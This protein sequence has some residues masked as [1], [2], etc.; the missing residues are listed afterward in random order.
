MSNIPKLRFPEFTDAWEKC[1]LERYLKTS[2][3]KNTESQYSKEDVLSVSGEFGI[4]NQIK[5]KGRSFAGA[6]VENYSIV[7]TGDVVYTKSPLQ[8]NPYGIIKANKGIAGIVST[9]YAVYHPKEEADP[10]FIQTYFELHSRT[11]N[12]L[13]PLVN[14]GA[15]NDMKV[16]SDNALKG[17]VIFPTLPEQQKI[18]TLF[19]RLDRLITLHKRKWDDVILLKKALLQKMFPKNGSDFPEIR[20]PEF[21]DAWEKCKLI[22]IADRVTRKNKKLESKLP[23]T[24]SAQDGL[25]SQNEFFNK[26]IASKDVSGYYLLKKG[27]FA[28][29]KS[30]SNGYPWGAIKRLDKYEMG[31]VSTLYICFSLK[32][33]INSDFITTYYDTHLWYKEISQISAEGARNHGL[34]NIATEDFFQTSISLPTLP[35]QQK[36][37]NLFKQL[38]RL[39]TLHKRQHEHYQLLKK[40]LLQQMFV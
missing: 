7:N 30:Y 22:N 20:F 37:G 27:E 25:I 33:H 31:V 26:Q 18:G 35:E 6:S 12:Y 5:F 9:L 8:N 2:T 15:K 17:G 21:T 24:I 19:R 13:A 36:I 3:L 14:K 32:D 34:L 16:S 10:E 4:V 11:N 38:D 28:Y 23:L 40:A 29:N 1:K 39:I